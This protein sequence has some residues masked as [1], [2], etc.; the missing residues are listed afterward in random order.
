MAQQ[1]ASGSRGMRAG[2]MRRELR[3]SRRGVYACCS[4]RGVDL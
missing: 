3:S 4:I 2:A 1:H